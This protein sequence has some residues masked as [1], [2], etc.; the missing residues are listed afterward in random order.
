MK[1]FARR[2]EIFADPEVDALLIDDDSANPDARWRV[3]CANGEI[4]EIEAN[5]PA[6]LPKGQ[7]FVSVER[8]RRRFQVTQSDGVGLDLS[9]VARRLFTEGRDR[10]FG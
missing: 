4:V 8:V 6:R 9:A 7:G 2:I 1:P 10:L 5:E 3:F